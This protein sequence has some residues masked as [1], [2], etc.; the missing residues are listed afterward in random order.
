MTRADGGFLV[1]AMAL[2]KPPWTKGLSH[3]KTKGVWTLVKSEWQTTWDTGYYMR[4]LQVGV[5]SRSVGK[6]SGWR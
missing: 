4:T 5:Q 2:D 6:K 1:A 3:R